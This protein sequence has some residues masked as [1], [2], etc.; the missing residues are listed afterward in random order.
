MYANEPVRRGRDHRDR[1]RQRVGA[2]SLEFSAG[3]AGGAIATTGDNCT[4]ITSGNLSGNF[5]TQAT[6]AAGLGH[7][8]Y[9]V[10]GDTAIG[11]QRIVGIVHGANQRRKVRAPGQHAVVGHAPVGDKTHRITGHRCRRRATRTTHRAVAR[12]RGRHNHQADVGRGRAHI[13][14]SRHCHRHH[15]IG[16]HQRDTGDLTRLT[17]VGAAYAQAHGQAG[18]STA[19]GHRVVGR[20]LAA[21]GVGDDDRNR[22]LIDKQSLGATSNRQ[23]RLDQRR[24]RLNRDA[25]R[26]RRRTTSVAGGGRYQYRAVGHG[27]RRATNAARH[28]VSATAAAQAV[29]QVGDGTTGHGGIV[30]IRLTAIVGEDDF[31]NS[32][33]HCKGL[34]RG[35]GQ[36]WCRY[37][38][39]IGTLKHHSAYL[40]LVRTGLQANGGIARQ[41]DDGNMRRNIGIGRRKDRP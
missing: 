11:P 32:L 33:A 6:G 12:G 1:R 22:L 27:H 2:G 40:I 14:G 9:T 10:G 18:R 20:Q 3:G 36:R 7:H 35:I 15:S 4:R 25:H 24:V 16:R 30:R 37:C 31:A 26:R 23:G 29:R 28:S 39:S 5:A 8:L 21:A 17:V 38:R 13:I 41:A 19:G 34:R